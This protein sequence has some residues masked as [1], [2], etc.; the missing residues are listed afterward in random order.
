MVTGIAMHFDSLPDPRRQA[1]RRHYLS[2]MLTIT[3]CAVICGA[4][5]WGAVAEFGEAKR[6][7]FAEH[8]PLPHGIPCEDTFERVF[9]RLDPEAFEQCFA[10]WM[11]ALAETHDA[12]LIAIDGKTLR[13]SF[14]WAGDKAAIHM[15]SAWAAKNELVFGQVATEA[16]SNEI[17]AIPRLLELLDLQGTTVTIDAEG[18]QKAIAGQIVEQGGDYVLALKT[19][20]P[21]MHHEVSTFLDDA[22]AGGF[23]N[24]AGDA[25][26]EVH[27]DHGR[28]ETRRVWVT[29]EVSWFE[30][31]G[32]WAGL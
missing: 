15:V 14:D 29:F 12:E 27:A 6:D 19:N 31:R 10:G 1:G 26:E 20:H 23:R 4:D 32:Q 5:D 22:I 17:T 13:R 28:I 8:L 16:K 24:I 2:D 25:Y 7:F 18:C 30:D 11:Q 9:A 3:I 21:T